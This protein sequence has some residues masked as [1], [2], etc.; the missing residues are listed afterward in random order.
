MEASRHVL[1]QKKKFSA[2]E[3]P[4]GYVRGFD[5]ARI[6]RK[7]GLSVDTYIYIYIPIYIYIYIYICEC[8]FLPQ[9]CR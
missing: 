8:V 5:K 7:L 3:T 1:F 6:N 2:T 4:I 9:S